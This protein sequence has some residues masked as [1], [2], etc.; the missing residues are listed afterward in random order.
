MLHASSTVADHVLQT[1][2]VPSGHLL[3]ALIS[4][5]PPGFDDGR[6]SSGLRNSETLY[7][8]KRIST[9]RTPARGDAIG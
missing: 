8:T 4:T 9:T 7:D 2:D 1:L 6:G 5:R 3:V